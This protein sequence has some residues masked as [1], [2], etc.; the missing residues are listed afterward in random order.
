MKLPTR[1]EK[2]PIIDAVFEVHV[3]GR[4]DLGSILPGL[5]FGALG[6]K[7]IERLPAADI[8][9]LL[10]QQNEEFRRA[11]MYR[12]QLE[13]FY[14]ALGQQNILVGCTLPYPRWDQFQSMIA[15]VI[16]ALRSFKLV[17]AINRYSI[18]YTNLLPATSA[19]DVL[20]KLNL[21]L[22]YGRDGQAPQSFQLRIEDREDK[23]VQ[24][25]QV[26]S[27][28][29]AVNPVDG[30]RQG[31]VIDIDTICVLDAPISIDEFATQATAIGDEVHHVNKRTFFSL[32]TDDT[33]S[34]LGAVYD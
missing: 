13:S 1:L 29:S 8:P 25:I 12:V 24:I 9:E 18:K 23:F 17:S 7:S 10:R 27:Q 16:D 4:P 5:F 15:K 6:G 20:G 22:R 26:F 32:L 28:A 30:E 31:S 33:I 3:E 14:V 19:A 34:E 21:N 11:L 2:E